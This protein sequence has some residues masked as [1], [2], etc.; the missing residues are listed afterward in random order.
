M[1]LHGLDQSVAPEA[2]QAKAMLDK[3]GGKWWTVYIGG[4]RFSGSG[5]TPDRVK[6]YKAHGIT[7]FLLIY[8]GRQQDDVSLLTASQGEHDGNEACQIAASFGYSAAGT[9]LCLDLE[10]VTFDASPQ[11]SLDYACGWCHAVRGHQLRPGVYSNPRALIPLAARDHRPDW[12][13]VASWVR[14]GVD[15]DADP[16]QAHGLPD[17]MWSQPGQ[18]VWQYAGTFD[19][20]SA[21]VDGI[22][23][24][25]SVADGHCIAGA[26][27]TGPPPP[28]PPPPPPGHT[29]TVRPGDTLA[30]IAARLDIAG[31]WEALYALNIAVIGPDP[32]VIHAGQVLRL[33]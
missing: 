7:R 25:I 11:G 16:H 1:T 2:G 27:L 20:I 4:P 30:A 13:W 31:G 10:G 33:P 32:D 6:Q 21:Q 17:S 29:Y 15:H 22:D 24:D 14:H 3:I 26:G 18:R 12:V 28:P 23:V 9:P 19:N 8:V 5:W